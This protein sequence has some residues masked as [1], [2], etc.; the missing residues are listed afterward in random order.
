M[1]GK[2]S[3]A[4]NAMPDQRKATL[5]ALSAVLMW[6]TVASAFKLSLRHMDPAQLLFY[7]SLASTACLGAILAVQGR[8]GLLV[9]MTRRQYVRSVLLG[10][11]NPFLYY[12][13]L[14]AAY[15]R[16]PAQLA[17]PINYTWAITLTLLSIPLL[18]QKISRR[19][20]AAVFVGYAGVL[21]ISTRGDVAGMSVE[22]PLGVGL[23]LLSTI[24]WAL[25]WIVGA[26]DDRDPVAGLLLNFAASLPM[27]LAVCLATTGLVPKSPLGYLG[28]AYVGI[29][30]MGLAFAL[31]LSAMRNAANTARIANLIFLSPFLSLVFIHFVVGEDI[32]PSTFAGLVLIMAGLAIQRTAKATRSA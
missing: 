18:G 14:F 20:L 26:R 31:W 7:S 29:F 10:A 11:L 17:Q 4:E 28:A 22:S 9:A 2:G 13:I 16:L 32:L 25:F 15:D 3:P 24:L 8:L 27:T 12:L 21:V 19:D 1:P 23:A 6:S 5:H 30:E